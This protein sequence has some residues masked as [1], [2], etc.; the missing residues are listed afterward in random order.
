MGIAKKLAFA[1]VVYITYQ[2]LTQ[3]KYEHLRKTIFNEYKKNKSNI[4]DTLDSVH[5]YLTIPKEMPDETVRI[6]IDQEIE[7]L[8]EK[9]RD[10]NVTKLANGA[11]QIIEGI[12][13]SISKTLLN[14]KKQK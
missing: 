9:I 10:L 2:L 1:S 11:S 13:D 14:K 7:L 4:L 12:N 8:K 5:T 3:K 6:K